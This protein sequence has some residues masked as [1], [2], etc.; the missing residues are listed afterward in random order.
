MVVIGRRATARGRIS[1]EE[2]VGGGSRASTI[3]RRVCW[4]RAARKMISAKVGVEDGG[5]RV[6]TVLRRVG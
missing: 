6:L 3:L 2:G 1:T 4:R 5:S